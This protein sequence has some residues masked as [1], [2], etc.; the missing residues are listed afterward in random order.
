MGL[1]VIGAGLGRTGTMSLK[2]ALER[3]LGGPC[4]HMVELFDHLE[5]HTPL[6]HAAARGEAVDWDR[7]FDGYVAAVDEPVSTQWQSITRYYPEA[8]V[9]LSLRDPDSWWASASE[10]IFQVASQPREAL[11]PPRQAWLDMIAETY[12]TLYPNGNSEPEAAKAAFRA[13]VARVMAGVPASRLL[14]W[15]VS[16]GWAPLCEALRL[17]VPDEPFPKTNSTEEFKA[18]PRKTI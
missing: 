4:Y 3:L 9:V 14:V 13:H 7:V 12:K 15:D 10:T 18:R 6:W 17:P 5:A 1:K 11:S 8:L 2:I 16:Q